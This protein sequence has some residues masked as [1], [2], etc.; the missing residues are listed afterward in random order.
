[1]NTFSQYLLSENIFLGL[2]AANK[3]QAFALIAERLERN[4]Q[5]NRA[6]VYQKLYERENMDSTGLGDGVAIPHAQVA[7]IS[8]P[9]AAF[10][11][12]HA[13]LDFA[14]PDGQPVSELFV[15]LLPFRTTRDHLQI[16]ADL[17]GMLCDPQFRARLE[18]AVEV[19]AVLQC[20]QKQTLAS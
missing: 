9:I 16:L 5:I 18:H 20:L 13:P 4:C 8:Q 14:A 3:L 10:V 17:A 1:M 6:S 15:L 7:G 12:L 11:R 2:H 19:P